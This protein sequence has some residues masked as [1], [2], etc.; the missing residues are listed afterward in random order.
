[1]TSKE[2]LAGCQERLEVFRKASDEFE[3]FEKSTPKPYSA[4]DKEKHKRLNG[5]RYGAA[6]RLSEYG[7]TYADRIA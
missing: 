4:E 5:A 1:M 6:M 7:A 3:E 2:F